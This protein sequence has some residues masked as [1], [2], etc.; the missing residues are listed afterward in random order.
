MSLSLEEMKA[1]ARRFVIEPWEKGNLDVLDEICAPDYTLE[2]RTN[3]Q[4]LKAAIRDFRKALPD[5]KVTIGVMVAEGDAAL[6]H[7]IL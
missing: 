1:I 6:K 2:G 7:I 4:D 3:L 5:L